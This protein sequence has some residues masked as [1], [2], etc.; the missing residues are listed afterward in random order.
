MLHTLDFPADLVNIPK[1]AE[2]WFYESGEEKLT[3]IDIVILAKLHSYFGSRKAKYLPYLNTIPAYV[4]LNQGKLNG[5]FS[6]NV[7]HKAQ[8]R[9]HEAMTFFS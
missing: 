2:D 5:D 9:I 8:E 3:L 7:L 1:F 6:L 4:K